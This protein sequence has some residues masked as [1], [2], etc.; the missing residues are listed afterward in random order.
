MKIGQIFL[1]RHWQKISDELLRKISNEFPSKIFVWMHI[2]S[3][4]LYI[5]VSGIFS[6]RRR[7]QIEMNVLHHGTRVGHIYISVQLLN[8]LISLVKFQLRQDTSVAFG[9]TFFI[10]FCFSWSC[11]FLRACIVYKNIVWNFGP[12]FDEFLSVNF[13][14][15]PTTYI[16]LE[17]SYKVSTTS[18]N[19]LMFGKFS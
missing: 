17:F 1:V 14:G 12:Q 16:L 13:H 2:F 8:L 10:R 4:S 3:C 5:F 6:L 9:R 15:L 11:F 7:V 19:L 18:K